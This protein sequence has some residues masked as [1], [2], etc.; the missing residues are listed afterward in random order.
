[1]ATPFNLTA[2]VTFVAPN[3]NAFSTQIRNTLSGGGGGGGITVPVN[4]AVAQGANQAVRQQA[5]SIVA[6]LI[7][8]NSSMVSVRSSSMK[9]FLGKLSPD[10][11]SKVGFSFCLKSSSLF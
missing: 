9:K 10:K 4:F 7:L 11:G 6:S 5:N 3:L 8:K 1:M 2:N